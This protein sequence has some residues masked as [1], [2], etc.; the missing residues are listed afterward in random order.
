MRK[1]LSIELNAMSDSMIRLDLLGGDC[2]CLNISPLQTE[3]REK[4]LLKIT[5][6]V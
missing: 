4:M 2:H 1:D 3:S 5:S 6:C